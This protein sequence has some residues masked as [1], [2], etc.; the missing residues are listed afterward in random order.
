[1]S[2]P[3]YNNG[4]VFIHA[5]DF[6]DFGESE[7]LVRFNEL[8]GKLN[9]TH[10]IVVAGNHELGFD[11]VEDLSQRSF[12]DSG[13]GT[14]NGYS[15]LT[16]A[17]Y[18]HDDFLTID[19]VK[20]LRHALPFSERLSLLCAPA[21][22]KRAPRILDVFAKE[23]RWGSNKLLWKVLKFKPE[24]HVFGHVHAGYGAIKSNDTT[25]INAALTKPIFPP[26]GLDPERKPFVFYVRRRIVE[27]NQL[28]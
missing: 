5:G 18:L 14:I 11:P 12:L 24:F 28:G 8:L 6:T 10:K 2:D 26:I 23:G 3:E 13:R 25:F 9:F 20:V 15:L 4:D 22:R 19:G 1:M 27:K 16:N 17:V 21:R 7:E